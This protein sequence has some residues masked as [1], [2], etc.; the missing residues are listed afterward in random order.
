MVL[1]LGLLVLGLLVIGPGPVS[2]TNI[3]NSSPGMIYRE[4]VRRL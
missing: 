2:K 3:Q 1:V 4:T